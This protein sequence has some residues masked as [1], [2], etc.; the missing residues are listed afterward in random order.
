M[1]ISR[2]VPPTIETARAKHAELNLMKYISESSVIACLFDYWERCAEGSV[3]SCAVLPFNSKSFRSQ[4]V[5]FNK[6]FN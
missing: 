4:L 3:S 2:S 1:A 6:I 5:T